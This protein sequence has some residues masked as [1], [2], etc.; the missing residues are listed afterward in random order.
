MTQRGS[1]PANAG[2]PNTLRR[3]RLSLEVDPRERGGAGARFPLPNVS[4]G[5]SPRT[6]G[7][8]G[9]SGLALCFLGSIP[10]NAGEP[11]RGLYDR[12]R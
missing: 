9:L 10:A 11:L 12:I 6:R 8:L 3:I 5:R 4:A 1:I 2:E 7:S